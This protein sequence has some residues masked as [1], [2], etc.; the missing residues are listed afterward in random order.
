MMNIKKGSFMK[1]A[2]F[3]LFSFL[4]WVHI[5]HAETNCDAAKIFMSDMGENVIS[6]L[7]NQSISDKERADQFRTILETQF[8]LKA[9]G[10]FVLGRYWKQASDEEKQTFLSL[11]KETT[12]ATYATRFKDYTSEK[13]E[14]RGC[15]VEPDG[16]VIVSSQI[17]RPNGQA[18]P[19]NWKIFE[20]KGEMRVYDVILEGISMGITQR[21]EFASVI[22]NGGGK[23]N[24]LNKALE[25]KI[26]QS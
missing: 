1:K 11:F 17:T 7:T 15:Q 24:A 3:T 2:V 14:I 26:S 18:I 23:L 10:K 19:I 21:S 9:I 16:G 25:K 5:A 20:K 13:F 8:N 4:T 6:L 12:V 22:Q